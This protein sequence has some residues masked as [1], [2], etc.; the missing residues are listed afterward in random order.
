MPAPCRLPD[1][2]LDLHAIGPVMLF[3]DLAR[4]WAGAARVTAE[5]S[6]GWPIERL[7]SI[8]RR[9]T[10]EATRGAANAPASAF[11]ITSDPGS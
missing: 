9:L 3:D 8:S 1:K 2:S 11:A 5:N 4:V 6:C 7:R 10:V